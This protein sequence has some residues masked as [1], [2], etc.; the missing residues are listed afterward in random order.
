[1]LKIMTE[2]SIWVHF[3]LFIELKPNDC[4]NYT[5]LNPF[6]SKKVSTTT[7]K[8]LKSLRRVQLFAISWTIQSME[9]S[10][11]EYWNGQPFLSPGDLP[12]PGIEPRSPALQVDSLPAEP[13]GKPKKTE[14]PIPSPADL[15]NPGI[16]LGSPAQQADSLPTELSV[17]PRF[18]RTDV[19][20]TGIV[21]ISGVQHSDV[22]LY[23]L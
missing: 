11:P 4:L 17:K 16:E 5:F 23:T 22:T 6:K 2:N 14:Q 1:M 8:K 13:P 19:Y 12:N 3:H 15:P 10:R 20:L 21:L 18:K 9:F 7:L